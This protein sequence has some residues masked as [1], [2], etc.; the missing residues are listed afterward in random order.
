MRGAEVSGGPEGRGPDLVVVGHVGTSIVHAG[1]VSWTAAGGS[2]Y[3]AAASAGALIGR[4]AGLV[5]AVGKD[6]DLVPLRSREVD[7]DGVA[8]LPGPSAKLRVREF[9]DG[10]RSFSAE[11]GVADTVRTETFPARYLDACYI[12]LGTAPPD[13]QLTW[14]E[15]LHERGC[16]AR[17]SADMF[18]HYV[19]TYPTASREVCDSVD[20][21]FMTQA[22]YD[23]LYGDAQ[24]PVPKAPLVVKRGL[25]GARLIVDGH[26]QEVEAA[27]PHVVD[28]GGGG[29]VLAGV[30]LALRTEGLPERTALKYAVRAA[31]SCVADYGVTGSHLAAELDAIRRETADSGEYSAAR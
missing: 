8:E 9:D 25:S 24:L 20:L 27:V 4:R 15:F 7:L 3:A 16:R 14:L 18:G 29:E 23:G 22:E 17:V 21:I 30:F 10:S 13:Q 11:L 12:H 2:G 5:A 6:F 26:P 31:A 28:P 1:A 19:A